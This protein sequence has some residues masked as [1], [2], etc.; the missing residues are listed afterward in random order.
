MS[1]YKNFT[2]DLPERIKELDFEFQ[3]IANEKT[4]EVSYLLMKLSSSFLLPYERID[5]NSGA[6]KHDINNSQRIRKDLELDKSFNKS[7]YCKYE[8]EWGVIEV[9]DFFS[10]PSGWENKMGELNLTVCKML[11]ILRHSIAHSNLYFRGKKEI[12]Y[13]YF[14]SRKERDRNTEKYKVIICSVKAMD[15]LINCWI[16]HLCN[17]KTSPWLIWQEIEKAA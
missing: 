6:R 11:E 12:E 17:L 1:E 5:G 15:T 16:D 9:N 3:K 13:I 8:R 10:G 4:L 14:G 7:G 2:V